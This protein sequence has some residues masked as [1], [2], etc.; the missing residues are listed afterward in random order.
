MHRLTTFNKELHPLLRWSMTC[1]ALVIFLNAC[2]KE[3]G[4][5]PDEK[6]P[7]FYTLP[8]GQHT[9]DDTIVNFQ[10]KYGTYILYKFS[11]GD[12]TWNVTSLLNYYA[13]QGNQGYI[14]DALKF[15]LSKTFDFY[16]E[17]FMKKTLPFKI[18]LAGS[19][20]AVNP[21]PGGGFD[22]V[23]TAPL[24]TTNGFNFVTLAI[25]DT[26][27]TMPAAS[28]ILVKGN[29]NYYYWRRAL[30]AGVIEYPAGFAALT[31]Y[32]DG[33][34]F[35]KYKDVGFL[36]ERT[37]FTASNQWTIADDFLYYIREITAKTT[38][39]FTNAYLVPAYDTKGMVRKKYDLITSYYK[40]KYGVDLQAIGDAQ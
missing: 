22:T 9:Y 27:S 32:A 21:K 31:N 1:F 8:Q 10:K 12:Y 14:S 30:T 18:I 40:T 24:F 19:Q 23:R 34:N 16:P 36:A 33:S 26:I 39:Q 4:I 28:L 25:T 35:T 38:T 5:T 17:N 6:Q 2:K 7:P 11:A 15:M 20:Y 3:E 13:T 29:F 37:L